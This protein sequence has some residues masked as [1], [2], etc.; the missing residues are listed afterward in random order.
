MHAILFL[1]DLLRRTLKNKLQYLI[2]VMVDFVFCQ[3][4]GQS[5]TF[6]NFKAAFLK[7]FHGTLVQSYMGKISNCGQ[8]VL[9]TLVK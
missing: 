6:P 1:K 4:V 7:V 5:L 9:K 3:N 8:K 2:G